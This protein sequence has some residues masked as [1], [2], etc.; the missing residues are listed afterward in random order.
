M[1]SAAAHQHD[2]ADEACGEDIVDIGGV[3]LMMG[4]IPGAARVTIRRSKNTVNPFP[5]P[6]IRLGTSHGWTRDAVQSWI[7]QR[8]GRG[9]GPRPNRP[10]DDATEK[11][12]T[13]LAGAK[14]YLTA[15]EMAK[16]LG[17]PIEHLMA[18]LDSDHDGIDAPR[19]IAIDS[20]VRYTLPSIR[21]WLRAQA[22][23]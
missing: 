1:G 8:P 10:T 5:E 3:A 22:D 20:R 18:Y 13:R 4:C 6:C 7:D 23:K 21:V 14:E 16:F 15:G 2:Y 9:N 11:R 12:L 19:A 17:W